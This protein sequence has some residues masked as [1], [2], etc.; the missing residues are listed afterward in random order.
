MMPEK[1]KEK[2]N[3]LLVDDQPGKL[4][5]YEVILSELDENLIKTSSAK[6]ALEILLKTDVAAILV[7][8]CMPELDG[9]ELAQMIREHPRFKDT[10]IIFI[11]AVMLSELDSLKAYEMGG[12]DYV[13]VPVV[14]GILRAK[15]RV[16]VDLYRKSRQLARA[17]DELE[18]RVKERTREL[19]AAIAQQELLA[20]EVDH[21]A[22]NALA[23][24]QSIVSMMPPAPGASMGRVIEGRIRAMARAHTLL[25]Q[26]RWEGADLSRLVNEEL[27]P[28]RAGDRVNVHGAAAAIRPAVAQN[29]A[30]AIHELA[31]NA[32]KYGALSVPEGKLEVSWTLGP[33]QLMLE[34]IESGGPESPPPK[35]NGFGTKVIEASI[36]RQL[37]GEI[38]SDWTS[39]G[40]KCVLRV[41]AEHF[42]PPAS[43]GPTRPQITV[44][45][46]PPARLATIRGR[47]VMLVEDEPLVSMMMSQMIRDLGGEVIGPFGTLEEAQCAAIEAID[48][49][50]LDVNVAG[51]LVYPLA[52]RLVRHSK[53]MVFLTGYDAGSLDD[54][55]AGS[56][57]L[58]KPIDERE[59]AGVLASMFEPVEP[60][61][62]VLAG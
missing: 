44:E 34:W 20:R 43:I 10:A 41:P 1:K 6:E 32:A 25:S 54:R 52:D 24:I 50:M 23:V 5:S 9:F 4:A 51:Q 45:E 12:V 40:L 11:S 28:F 16:F 33:E 13:S 29:F 8:V 15:V 53:P 48:A 26:A 18:A 22:R 14:P 61:T 27:E 3:I 19:E 7:D 56:P 37:N 42:S 30:L 38:E 62:S 2:A 35:K 49:A 58:T 36:K 46:P 39:G 59:L 47:R 21:R 57:V 60:K 31:T 17:N 55:F